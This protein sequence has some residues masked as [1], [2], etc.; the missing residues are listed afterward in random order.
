MFKAELPI[1]GAGFAHQTKQ[2]RAWLT[3]ITPPGDPSSSGTPGNT[4]SP[5]LEPRAGE[6][7]G[8]PQA[9]FTLDVVSC[10]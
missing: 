5:H 1:V 9:L 4:G 7:G 6:G 8:G 10:P 2:V 3:A